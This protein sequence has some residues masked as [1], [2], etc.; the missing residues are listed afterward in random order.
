MEGSRE[1]DTQTDTQ[2][3]RQTETERERDRKRQTD[4]QAGR[5][6]GRQAETERHRHR[7]RDR[8]GRCKRQRGGLETFSLFLRHGS[9]QQSSYTPNSTAARRNLRRRPHSCRKLDSQCSGDRE[10]EV[11]LKLFS[12]SMVHSECNTQAAGTG[13]AFSSSRN[14]LRDLV[15]LVG[16][17]SLE[18]T[19]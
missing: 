2:T 1:T 14:R 11:T 12:R 16:A 18:P 13:P 8:D 15:W 9:Q 17:L 5:Q 7:D 4:R 6:A 10:E 3:D 19:T